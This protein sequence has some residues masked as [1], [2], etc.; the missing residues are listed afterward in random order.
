MLGNLFDSIINFFRQF[1]FWVMVEPWEQAMRVRLGK[2]VKLLK[3]GV[4]FRVPYMDTVHKQ[5]S[6]Y[7]TAICPSQTLTTKDGHTVVCSFAVGYALADIQKLYNTMHSA[8]DTITQTVAS[9]VADQVTI[10]NKEGLRAVD[11]SRELTVRLADD[12]QKYGLKEVSVRLQDF[13][14]IK[15]FRLIQ[16]QRYSM[17]MGINTPPTVGA[18]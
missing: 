16:D 1:I 14:F 3:P 4:H 6:R 18:Y 2:H 5:S 11:I 13:A 9:F 8:S 12:F 10:T 7:R 15:A 17:D